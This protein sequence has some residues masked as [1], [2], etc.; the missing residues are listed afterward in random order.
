MFTLVL[1]PSYS[2]ILRLFTKIDIDDKKEN[3]EVPLL[4]VQTN[5]FYS[6]VQSLFALDRV[7]YYL[8]INNHSTKKK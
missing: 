4:Y 1:F 7:I 5:N 8:L 2:R 6:R 3:A